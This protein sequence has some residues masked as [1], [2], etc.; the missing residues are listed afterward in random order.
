MTG[1][2][3]RTTW[4]LLRGG[5]RAGAAR[6]SLMVLGFAVGVTALLLVQAVPGILDSR[7]AT[8]AARAPARTSAGLQPRLYFDQVTDTY[9]DQVWTRVLLSAAP[10]A[11]PPP[12]LSRVPAAGEV[13]VSPRL[14]ESAR[15]DPALRARLGGQPSLTVG[16]AGLLGPDEQLS[17]AGVART[18]LPDGGVPAS[19]YGVTA[20]KPDNDPRAGVRVE[21]LLLIGAPALLYLM[22]CSRLSAATRRKRLAALRLLGFPDRQ[23]RL[24]SALEAGATGLAG[25]IVGTLLFLG[26]SG[27]L[28]RSSLFGF[29][30]YE[31]AARPSGLA[32]VIDLAVVTVLAA[33]LGMRGT[34][35]VLA[36]AVTTRRDATEATARWWRTLPLLAAVGLL[37]VLVARGYDRRID[38][39]AAQLVVVGVVVAAVGLVLAL[40]PTVAAAAAALTN[41]GRSWETRIGARRLQVESDSAV[42]LVTG[43]LLLVLVASLGSAVLRDARLTAGPETATQYAEV[44]GE[45]LPDAASRARVSQLPVGDRLGKVHSNG[46]DLGRPPRNSAEQ[47]AAFGV[48]VVFA[49]CSV[50][51]RFSPAPLT[52][53]ADGR[54]YQLADTAYVGS[55]GL[56]P[57]GARAVVPGDTGEATYTVPKDAFVLPGLAASAL[58]ASG[59]LITSSAPPARGWGTHSTFLFAVPRG[60]GRLDALAGEV[61]LASPTA[62][63]RV[64][65]DNPEQLE[66]YRVHRGSVLV[67]LSVGLLLGAVAFG[68][69][70]LDRALERRRAVASLAVVGVSAWSLRRAQ[71]VQLAVPLVVGLGSAAVVGLLAGQAYLEAGGQQRGVYLPM[72]ATAVGCALAACL[73]G[74]VTAAFVPGFRLRAEELRRE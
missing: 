74:G 7:A 29:D 60:T 18:A 35:A 14:A 62:Q 36:D 63:V 73:V 64:L 10:G 46:R 72:V 54:T 1:V 56:L 68:I 3:L 2:A 25:A 19:G 67:G 4:R 30:W 34:R 17:Y 13:A 6:L 38:G 5:G 49:P 71:L 65:F 59:L 8:A 39:R 42:R 66:A 52:G 23:I 31:S 15:R 9:R 16:P 11:P 28:S 21:L 47:L 41:G 27:P 32:L 53:C 40:R 58:P 43:L 55:V 57:A 37:A 70:G 26:L 33:R 12:G 69:A 45:T 44:D 24:V 51:A 22:T 20:A 48:D 61:S 50:A